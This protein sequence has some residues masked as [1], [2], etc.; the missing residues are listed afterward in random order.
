MQCRD[1]AWRDAEAPAVERRKIGAPGAAW[2]ERVLQDGERD[3]A[4]QRINNDRIARLDRVS[5]HSR[6]H[7]VPEVADAHPIRLCGGATVFH[8]QA[9]FCTAVA[10]MKRALDGAEL[11]AIIDPCPDAH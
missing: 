6:I 7:P 2:F 1:V 11:W 3:I 9:P 10:L 4:G 5:R 8:R